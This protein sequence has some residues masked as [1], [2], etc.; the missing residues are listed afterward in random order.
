MKKHLFL[1]ILFSYCAQ[2]TI[3]QKPS[4]K[5][6]PLNNYEFL[7]INTRG[8]PQTYS[9]N[10][11]KFI[12]SM[13]E[14]IKVNNLY[15][16]LQDLAGNPIRQVLGSDVIVTTPIRK[17]NK[18]SKIIV[19]KTEQDYEIALSGWA[20]KHK[21][22]EKETYELLKVKA[23][24]TELIKLAK[25][26]T[27]AAAITEL[28]EII[29]FYHSP[30]KKYP[31]K[32]IVKEKH[33]NYQRAFNPLF[34]L[35]AGGLIEG[36]LPVNWEQDAIIN[37]LKVAISV[38]PEFYWSKRNI[39]TSRIYFTAAHNNNR[40]KLLDSNTPI[41][42]RSLFIEGSQNYN[43][44]VQLRSIDNISLN[45]RTLNIG[46]QINTHIGR[47]F[48]VFVEG[49]IRK[50][51]TGY[52]LQFDGESSSYL[53]NN[54]RID[55]DKINEV[56]LNVFEDNTPFVS[57]GINFI[58]SKD[59]GP[60]RRTL[61]GL[62]VSLYTFFAKGLQIRESS[63]ILVNEAGLSQLPVQETKNYSPFIG[64]K[65]GAAIW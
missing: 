21:L 17:Y 46:V 41:F 61:R 40:Y 14:S 52:K 2:S 45:G 4:I 9:F 43:D 65:F 44:L 58:F 24:D 34:R 59:R 62:S 60:K 20:Y 42:L 54:D 23:D 64:L 8:Y 28:N 55:S 56:S 38:L 6:I 39:I 37:T 30:S 32:L 53:N 51:L 57:G 33:W 12:S 22:D 19:E 15:Y 11:Q 26:L 25:R 47:G 35:E 63:T 3:A 7:V 18:H 31:L 16:I 13:Q 49:G 10:D 50:S 36:S 27:I 1:L 5:V 29:K 48:A